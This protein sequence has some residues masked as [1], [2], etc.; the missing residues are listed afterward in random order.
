MHQTSRIQWENAARVIE[1][2]VTPSGIHVC[3][4]NPAFPMQVRFLTL[5]APSSVALRRHDYFEIL[6]MQSGSAVYRV[7]DREVQVNQGDLFVIGSQCITVFGNT[8]RH[9]FERWFC[10]SIHL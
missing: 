10:T 1:P 7:P 4:L 9:K 5:K 8:L 6:Y 3:P 2:R